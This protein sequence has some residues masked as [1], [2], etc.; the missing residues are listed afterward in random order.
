MKRNVLALSVT[1][2]ACALMAMSLTGCLKNNT[3]NTQPGAA[4]SILQASPSDVK[5][6]LYFNTEKV[7]TQGPMAYPA[8][9]SK[10]VK[11]GTYVFSLVNTSSGD[12]LVQRTD[13]LQ[14][15]YYS[16]IVY[17]TGSHTDMT[18]F[19]DQFESSSSG[20]YLRFLQLSP[21]AGPVNFYIATSTDTTL[22]SSNRTFADNVT[23]PDQ[24]VFKGL[25]QGVYSFAAISATSGDTLASLPNVT[26]TTQSASAYTLM[27]RG[28]ASHGT[29]SLGLKLSLQG[30][31]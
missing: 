12:T 21:D 24:A 23:D 18:I 25:D 4:V 26:L 11:T 3:D 31:Y 16:L 27:L 13:S 19:Q 17:D 22:A 29:D 15:A 1:S 6:D 2:V 5:M 28:L 7:N 14:S 20:M 10:S 30:N 8:A 9:G